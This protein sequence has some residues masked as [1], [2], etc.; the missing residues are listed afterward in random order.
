MR[1]D[2]G[3]T[4]ELNNGVRMPMLGLGVWRIP[5]GGKAKEAVLHAFAAGY[6]LIDTAMMYANEADVGAAFRE[7]GLPRKDV[8]I[9]TK[10]WKQHQ[11]F[12]RATR[13][14]ERSLKN[15]GLDYVDLYLI[16]WPGGGDRIGSWKAM[17]KLYEEGKCRAIGV[18][19]FTTDHLDELLGKC[20]QVPS[21]NQVEFHPFL[22]QADLLRYCRGRGIQLEAYSP[23]THAEKLHDPRLLT[24]AGRYHKTPAQVLIRWG[25][26]HQVVEIPKSS[27]LERIQE[28]ADVFDFCLSEEDMSYLNRMSEGARV[29]W[30]PTDVL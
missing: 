23:L 3:S 22:Y 11:G 25:L 5:T 17:E 29:S 7:S 27:H 9:T 10:L 15:L 26:Q 16:H 30:D 28:N 24:V 21:V 2:I 14:F 12:E 18:S 8:F 19:N 6:R 4:V 1:L 13:A 20:R